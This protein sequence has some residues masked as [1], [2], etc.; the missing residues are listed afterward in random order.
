MLC[1]VVARAQLPDA[2]PAALWAQTRGRRSRYA[3]QAVSKTVDAFSNFF[4]IVEETKKLVG[5]ANRLVRGARQRRI[6]LCQHKRALICNLCTFFAN[7]FTNLAKFSG[8]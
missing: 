2:K 6:V 7:V 4:S 1:G 8:N 3:D 5:S